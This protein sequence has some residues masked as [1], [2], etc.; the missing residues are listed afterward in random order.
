MP[1]SQ[2]VMYN[3]K[4]RKVIW[5]GEVI[6]INLTSSPSSN[7]EN[8]NWQQLTMPKMENGIYQINTI[9]LFASI[10]GQ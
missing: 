1:L 3:R 9:L 6:V 2:L 4:L 7:T 10:W 8:T 5:E